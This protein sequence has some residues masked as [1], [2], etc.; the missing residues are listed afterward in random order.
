[1]TVALG[2]IVDPSGR[3]ASFHDDEISLM[4]LEDGREVIAIGGGIEKLV[5][6]SFCVEEA[7]HGI[8]FTEIEGEN[9]HVTSP[10]RSWRVF[11]CD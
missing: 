3:S 8:E 10:L 4:L 5:F 6:A 1:M 7:A 11:E 9:F 2:E